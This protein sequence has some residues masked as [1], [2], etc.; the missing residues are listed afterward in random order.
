MIFEIFSIVKLTVGFLT[1]HDFRIFSNNHR[2]FS[3]FFSPISSSGNRVFTKHLT[4]TTLSVDR[5][6]FLLLRLL[7][8]LHRIIVTVVTWNRPLDDIELPVHSLISPEFGPSFS[9]V[10]PLPTTSIAATTSEQDGLFFFLFF[11]R[12]AS[13]NSFGLHKLHT[14]TQSCWAA[15]TQLNSRSSNLI[16][17]QCVLQFC[18]HFFRC[19]QHYQH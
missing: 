14:D 1:T 16:V 12:L 2:I 3:L 7:Y 13:V 9:V 5:N 6:T 17:S 8:L 11:S 18:L 10:C 4:F 19:N 15:A